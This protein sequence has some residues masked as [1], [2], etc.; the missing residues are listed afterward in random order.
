MKL[1][2]IL[3]ALLLVFVCS[4]LSFAAIIIE[5]RTGAIKIFMPDGKQIVVLVNEPLPTI[6][7][8]A[9][10]TILAGSATI[11]TTGK[12]TVSVSI[13]TYTVGLKEDSKINLTLNPDGTM[14]STVLAGQ[15]VVSRKIEAY[16]RPIPPGMPEFGTS[17]QLEEISPSQ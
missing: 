3:L 14:T 11:G 16:E 17:G 5:N 8:G 7:D 1:R 12:S 10:V 9:T 13:G 2:T 6:P 15:S 4:T